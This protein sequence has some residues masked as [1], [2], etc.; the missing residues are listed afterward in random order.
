M[1]SHWVGGPAPRERLRYMMSC[2]NRAF[3]EL[4]SPGRM[5]VGLM[6]PGPLKPGTMADLDFWLGLADRAD[7]LGFGALWARDVPL[8]IPQGSDSQGSS[9]DDPFLWLA[10]LAGATS[11]VAL[12]TA[13]VVLPLRQPLHLA[14]SA[15]TLDRVSHGRFV[16]GLGSGDRPEEFAPFAQSLERRGETFRQHW[17]LVRSAL[18]PEPERR[19]LLQEA[20]GGF[21]VMYPPERQIP[22]LAIGS[23]R[24]TLQWI[25]GHAEGWATYYRARASQAGRLE[26]WRQAVLQKAGEG[27][28][29]LLIQS[30]H[31]QL[32]ED[33][34][35][36]AEPIE[37][38]LRGGRN[39]VLNRLLES[40]ELGV[41][42]VIVVLMPTPRPN[43]DVVQELGEE[44]IPFL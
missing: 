18:E 2:F 3:S 26:L 32:L 23:A 4:H 14:K 11:R 35:A 31:L 29:R 44:V 24:Q 42:H 37:L 15:L 20:T 17:D 36:P 25:A 9:L 16:L 7:R 12:G 39:A 1:D 43:E 30:T 19:R 27:S 40:K 34:L 41:D 33:P 21:D 38:G 6:S 13:G 10:A 28:K 8:V 22:M 5:T